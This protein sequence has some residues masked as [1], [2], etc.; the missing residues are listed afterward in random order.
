MAA[1][2]RE[3]SNSN[4]LASVVVIGEEW[5]HGLKNGTLVRR[6]PV[7]ASDKDDDHM[8]KNWERYKRMTVKASALTK[9]P[10]NAP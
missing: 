7:D 4:I 2:A 1:P 3:V 10:L 6:R 9:S 5:A 8:G